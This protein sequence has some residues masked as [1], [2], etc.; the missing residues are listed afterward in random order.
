MNSCKFVQIQYKPIKVN[1]QSDFELGGR[2]NFTSSKKCSSDG[3]ELNTLIA[4]DI[5][6]S[7]TFKKSKAKDKDT[8]DSDD[9]LKNFT[10]ENL[11]IITEL[12]PER[13]H[14]HE[15][16][17][18]TAKFFTEGTFDKKQL[19]SLSK[20]INQSIIHLYHWGE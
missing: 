12:N 9:E 3:K 20:I 18:A 8:S 11:D 10:F 16:C 6:K 2:G 1:Q 4:S 14:L 17:L 15:K 13:D 19:Y 7:L 5:S